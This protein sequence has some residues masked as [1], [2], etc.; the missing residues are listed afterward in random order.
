MSSYL[1]NWI[2]LILASLGASAV[3]GISFALVVRNT[4]AT[5]K[6]QIGILTAAGLSLGMLIYALVICFGLDTLFSHR[7][8]EIL[9]YAGAV[10][11]GYIGLKSVFQN[12]YLSRKK[13]LQN[14][15]TDN[16]INVLSAFSMG[17]VT[18]ILNPKVMIFFI[19]LFS[20]FISDDTP[21]SVSL[22][23]GFT[24]VFIEFLWFSGLSILITHPSFL[25]TIKNASRYIEIAMGIIFIILS[26]S[27]FINP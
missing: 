12:K 26:V 4:L 6:R 9:K 27:V 23:Y 15:Y 17:F 21:L 18:N 1:S 24:S 19:A 25:E 16:K 20:Q 2:L 22:T 11:L 13:N 5:S 8:R 10:Y 14:A 3:P 7:I